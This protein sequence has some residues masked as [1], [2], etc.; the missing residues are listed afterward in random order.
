[1]LGISD[2]IF[3]DKNEISMA[4]RISQWQ[5]FL[6]FRKRFEGK[7]GAH[8]GKRRNWKR[9]NFFPVPLYTKGI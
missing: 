5:G 1:L 4:E 2:L 7:E 3:K 6:L 8:E 9:K